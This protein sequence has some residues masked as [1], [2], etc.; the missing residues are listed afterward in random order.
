M[1][2][3]YVCTVLENMKKKCT[4][5]NNKTYFEFKL[6]IY[7]SQRTNYAIKMYTFKSYLFIDGKKFPYTKY[8]KL[9]YHPIHYIHDTDY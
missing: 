5:Y 7:K 2:S 9:G 1:L 8:D 4:S 6:A 3:W